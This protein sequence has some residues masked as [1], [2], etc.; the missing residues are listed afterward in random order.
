MSDAPIITAL[1]N[2]P[3]VPPEPTQD[4]RTMAVL[5]HA[6]QMVGGWIAPLII[7]FVKSDSKFVRFHALQ[8]LM[9]QGCYFLAMIGMMIVWF[10]VII[11]TAFG[12]V[13]SQGHPNPA[14]PLGFFIV[15]PFF[16][17]FI[18]GM[19]V[20]VLVLTIMFAIKA[21]RGEWA[22]YPVLGKWAKSILKIN[23]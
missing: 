3:A 15:F 2:V 12:A 5:A 11:A 16:W 14:P 22:E 7:F 17:L 1:P 4:E 19:W 8:V 20:M 18:M 13:A 23:R 10:V 9:L 6:L 21:G